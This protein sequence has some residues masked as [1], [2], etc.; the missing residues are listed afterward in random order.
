M[1]LML[2]E[3]GARVAVV[4]ALH[5]RSVEF[6]LSICGPWPRTS[7]LIGS[8]SQPG[9]LRSRA[10]GAYKREETVRIQ[11]AAESRTCCQVGRV[12][13][14]FLA[15]PCRVWLPSQHVSP[16]RVR[17]LAGIQSASLHVFSPPRDSP[18]P[19]RPGINGPNIGPLLQD[20]RGLID[21]G[22]ND[23]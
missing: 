2:R 14:E 9:F 6:E 17:K 23:C 1:V 16:S 20:L 3:G 21:V 12:D 10:R 5:A 8:W 11:R 7:I 18:T 19:G 13:A 15:Q 22:T 4:A